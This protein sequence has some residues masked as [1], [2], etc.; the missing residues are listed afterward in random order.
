MRR[1]DMLRAEAEYH[2][3]FPCNIWKEGDEVK[4]LKITLPIH[5]E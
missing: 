5:R 4:N 1:I 3:D 2:F